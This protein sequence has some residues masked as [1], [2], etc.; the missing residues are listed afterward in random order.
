MP[1]LLFLG[2]IFGLYLVLGVAG[3]LATPIVILGVVVFGVVL[4]VGG[5]TA[6]RARNSQWELRLD[7]A[8]LTV[9]GHRLVP[10]ADL[11]E[12]R[13]TGLHPRWLFWFSAGY[14]VV[15]FIGKPGVE[16]PALPSTSW[17]GPLHERSAR[18][19]ERF[20]GSQLIITPYAMN[21]SADEITTNVRR[22]STLHI[23]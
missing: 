22:W 17:Q 23:R 16:L 21:A 10:W 2:L 20:Y 19:R 6:L 9:R 8:G 18:A 7:P 15:S 4:I 1:T 12:M 13:I 3:V 5:V 11:A 14:R